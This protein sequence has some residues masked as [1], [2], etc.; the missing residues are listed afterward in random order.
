M[1]AELRALLHDRATLAINYTSA[2]L[3]VVILFLMVF[4]PGASHP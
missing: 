1:T 2:V 3:L 4:K